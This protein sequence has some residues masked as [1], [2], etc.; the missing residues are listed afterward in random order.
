[1]PLSASGFTDFPDCRDLAIV[2]PVTLHVLDVLRWDMPTKGDRRLSKDGP[3]Y[4]TKEILQLQ[5]KTVHARD[6]AASGHKFAKT[7]DSVDQQVIERLTKNNCRP[8]RS[9]TPSLLPEAEQAK[10]KAR[11][12]RARSP[13]SSI[14]PLGDLEQIWPLDWAVDP[15][16]VRKVIKALQA[17]TADLR[18]QFD[19]LANH[20][21]GKQLSNNLHRKIHP[22]PPRKGILRQELYQRN[23]KDLHINLKNPS[24]LPKQQNSHRG[25]R[26]TWVRTFIRG[27]RTQQS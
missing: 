16:S 13:S 8:T 1:M 14:D 21:S 4:L 27:K 22:H 20:P 17:A 19:P 7:I 10:G 5:C 12:D 24:R 25:R 2:T 6:F 9:A 11:D 26:N 3:Y 23:H 18:L 15:S